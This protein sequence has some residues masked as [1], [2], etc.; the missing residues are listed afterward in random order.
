MAKIKMS[1]EDEIEDLESKKENLEFIIMDLQESEENKEE[2]IADLKFEIEL[3]D[4]ELDVLQSF[5][6]DE[7]RREREHEIHEYWS[8]AL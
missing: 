1:I 2:E 3:I 4:D 5:L 7:W 6:E 8:M